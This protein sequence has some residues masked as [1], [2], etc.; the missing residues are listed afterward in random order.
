M[1]RPAAIVTGGARGIGLACAEALASA[2]FAIRVADLANEAAHGLAPD[3]T[4]RGANFA[5]LSGDHAALD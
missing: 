1:S 5:L 2:G 4:G 3:I